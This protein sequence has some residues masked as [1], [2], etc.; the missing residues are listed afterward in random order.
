VPR[1]N[2]STLRDKRP[3]GS[4]LALPHRVLRSAQWAALSSDAVKA[5]MDLLGQYTA[6]N[7]GDLAAGWTLMHGL[8]W[9]SRDRMYRALRELEGR[10]WIVR[11]RQGGSHLPTLYGVTIYAL[12]PSPKIH[13]S[14][15]EWQR[16]HRGQWAR[17]PPDFAPVA[18]PKRRVSSVPVAGSK[19]LSTSR[20]P[21]RSSPVYTKYVPVA[22][23][24]SALLGKVRPG[25][26]TPS[27][28]LPSLSPVS[29]PPPPPS[30]G[31]ELVGANGGRP[32]G[33]AL[34]DD[35]PPRRANGAGPPSAA[36]LEY[37][38]AKG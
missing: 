19:L 9:R 16:T 11:T 28:K 35:S 10:G 1:K 24:F 37:L 25:G 12:D 3:E 38:R 8:G 31:C 13:V 30:T 5:L 26:R 32:G 34:V 33:I 4:F 36:A 20:W 18:G 6:H 22:G 23:P 21:D 17:V 15:A 27:K 2:R 14:E 29:G 7:N